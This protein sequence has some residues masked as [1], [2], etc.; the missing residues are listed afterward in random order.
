MGRPTQR[1]TRSLLASQYDAPETLAGRQLDQ[2]CSLISLAGT[3]SPFYRRTGLPPPEAFAALDDMTRLPLLA[4]DDLARHAKSM[5]VEMGHRRRLCDHSS[6]S[7]GPA[8]AYYW[9]RM[10]QAW[11]K[12]NRARG[13]GWLGFA[14]GDRELHLW[15]ADPPTTSGERFR[16]A[17]RT[18][19]DALVGDLLI[20]SNDSGCASAL[21]QRWRQFDPARVTAFPS[22]LCEFINDARRQACRLFSPSLRCVFLTGEVTHA[23]QKSLIE[24]ELGVETAQGYGVQEAGAVAFACERGVWHI[25]SESIIV[26]FIHNGRAAAPG[27]LAEVVVTSLVNRTMPLIRYRTGDIVRTAITPPCSCGRTLPVMPPVIGRFGDFVVLASG[28]W[29]EPASVIAHIGDVIQP[30]SFQVVQSESGRIEILV[31]EGPRTRSDWREAVIDRMAALAGR[32]AAVTVRRVPRLTRCASGKMR[33][34]Q[35][36]LSLAAPIPADNPTA[37]PCPAR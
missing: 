33:Y 26:E 6:G 10:R 27:E 1:L 22:R 4:R 8:V 12:A 25:C 37:S 17:L 28:E 19:R 35:S 15:P 34:V 2:L 36:Q 9:D 30:G 13:H 5:C 3:A 20:D 23:W 24:R 21:W 11:D 18:R 14:A 29:I 16:S 32:D 7:T 31:V